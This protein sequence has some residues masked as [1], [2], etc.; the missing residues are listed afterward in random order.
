MRKNLI[1]KLL[2]IISSFTI[3]F[4][5]GIIITLFVEGLP[6]FNAVNVLKFITGRLWYPTSEPPRFGILSLILASVG[7]TGLAVVI[8]VPLSLGSAIFISE[9]CPSSLREVLKPVIELLA[10]IPSVVYGFFGMVILAPLVQEWFNLPTGLTW[11]TASVILSI[12]IVPTVA[13]IAEDAI[14]AVPRD[15]RRASSALGAT[16]WETIVR[17][18]LPGASSGIATAVVLGVGRAIGETMTVLMVAGGAIMMPSSIFKPVR[19]MTATIAAEMGE[20][21]FGSL[22]YHALFAIALVLFGITLALNVVAQR[23][24]AKKENEKT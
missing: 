11:F 23:I 15:L 9:L 20:A 24:Y 6:T 3:V 1:E 16:K 18:V 17:V 13:S 2:P 5:M 21:P 4:L 10:S 14:G 8:A 19:P 7:V 22:H 12:M